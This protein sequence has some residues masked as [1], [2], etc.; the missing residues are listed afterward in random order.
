MNTRFWQD[1]RK[2]LQEK[3]DTLEQMILRGSYTKSGEDV[4]NELRASYGTLL[5]I[6]A[7][8]SII[9]GQFKEREAH[10]KATAGLTK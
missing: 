7:I 10:L 5:S 9:E 3:K 4:T 1:Y 2:I 6:I 8:P